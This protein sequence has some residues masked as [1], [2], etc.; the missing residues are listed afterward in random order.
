MYS[1]FI[2]LRALL[3]CN[4]TL[5]L[6]KKTH[7]DVASTT[8]PNTCTPVCLSVHQSVCLS[9][10]YT[11]A[12]LSVCPSVR[13]SVYYTVACLSVRL[14]ASYQSLSFRLYGLSV[15]LSACP[16][17][18][19]PSCLHV[20]GRD[21]DVVLVPG[22]QVIWIARHSR[23]VSLGFIRLIHISSAYLKPNTKPASPH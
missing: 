5:F 13:L 2:T 12:C 23:W 20:S 17:V 19:L 6:K 1:I 14:S 8:L 11:V 18:P 22:P 21:T 7:S 9:V 15:C 4:D 10:S 3:N 16:S